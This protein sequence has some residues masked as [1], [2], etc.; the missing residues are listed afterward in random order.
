MISNKP[1]SQSANAKFDFN[2]LSAQMLKSFNQKDLEAAAIS[3]LEQ[4]KTLQHNSEL[5]TAKYETLFSIS[6]NPIFVLD[7]KGFVR[8]ANQ[9]AFEITGFEKNE[10]LNKHFLK[11]PFFP[12]SE[13][14]RYALIFRQI[15]K[16]K[17]SIVENI[18]WKNKSGEFRYSNAYCNLLHDKKGK[19]LGFIGVVPD[20]TENMKNVYLRSKSEKEYL[21][22]IEKTQIALLTDDRA[23]KITSANIRFLELF[24]YNI[25][26]LKKLDLRGWVHPEDYPLVM[27]NHLDRLNGKK[28]PVHYEYRAISK[29][30]K[31]I[32]CEVEVIPIEENGIL[33]GT[34][35]YLWDISKRKADELK[36][37]EQSNLFQSVIENLTDPFYVIDVKDYSIMLANSASGLKIGQKNRLPSNPKCF[38]LTHHRKTPCEGDEH[39]CPVTQILE[40]GKPC[41]SEHIHYDLDGKPRTV[42]I[43]AFPILNKE[44]EITQIIEH[45][46][47]ITDK[48]RA[49]E[50]L[51]KEKKQ[52]QAYLDIAAVMLVVLD[53]NQNIVL[54][55]KQGLK[56]LGYTESELIGKNWFDTVIP[57]KDRAMVKQV[58]DALIAGRQEAPEYFENIVLTKNGEERLIA[59]NNSCLPNDEGKIERIISSGEDITWKRK[60]EEEL[61]ESE[62]KYYDLFENHSAAK[63]IV[64]IETAQIIDCNKAA[65][66][67][68]GWSSNELKSMNIK[69]INLLSD[70]EFRSTMELV[71]TN[72]QKYFEFKHICANG[73]IKD[74]EVYAGMVTIN[75]KQCI[76]AV[77]HDI[78]DR[79]RSEFHLKQKNKIDASMARLYV[80][81]SKPHLSI[82]EIAYVIYYEALA[83]TNSEFCYVATIDYENPDKLIAH[84]LSEMLNDNSCTVALEQKQEI[85]FNRSKDGKF[86]ALFGVSL[87]NKEAF[88]TNDAAQHPEATGV[89]EGHV[90]IEK[91]LSVPVLLNQELVGQIAIANPK[92]DYTEN[93]L[94]AITHLAEYMAL[95]I[96]RH[97]SSEMLRKSEERFKT[98]AETSGEWIWEV[99]SNGLFTYSSPAVI[100]INGFTAE[101]LVGKKHF[102]DFYDKEVHQSKMQEAA[103]LFKE[104]K[105][106]KGIEDKII[107][108]DGHEISIETKGIPIISKTGHFLGFMGS[109][110]NITEKKKA[111]AD[112][113][114]HTK[115]LEVFNN[116]MVD[117]EMRIIEMKEEVN[118]MCQ[119]LNIEKKYPEN[120][121]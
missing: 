31:I 21:D 96:Q 15:L 27:K 47:D 63:L 92:V 106:F 70:E 100:D 83:L 9:Q 116:A 94:E 93:D 119:L 1:N 89:P 75:K 99:D 110:I 49:N 11:L 59:W 5:Q 73:I 44:N 19:V 118:R 98:V 39:P 56:L 50:V 10:I 108:K 113:L 25:D 16:G 23:G 60:S 71:K 81:L 105:S 78:S 91:F 28:A 90:K 40:T 48:I 87:N 58:F 54:C 103:E 61:K 86:P 22:L 45:A 77:I 42:E 104:M 3:I 62:K 20:I 117:R 72:K 32:W 35:S 29:T 79:K 66:D 80:P 6:P 37:E 36:I 69:Q 34:R 46:I 112:L 82:K 67:F 101:E 26:E 2:D 107:H 33:T 12:I 55:N 65:N 84:T 57:K 8:E 115:E 24:E 4:A 52:T 41:I 109:T 111:E 17:V 38:E 74:V 14:L 114:K 68:Y 13:L 85:V 7:K 53:V 51:S 18:Q 121:S 64:D 97:K 120:W 76:H 43:R 88:Y 30:G 102:F 95:A